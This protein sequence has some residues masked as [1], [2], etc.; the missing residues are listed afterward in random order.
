LF[1]LRILIEEEVV[2]I[3]EEFFMVGD[4]FIEVL[5]LVLLVFVDELFSSFRL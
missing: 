2:E 1:S 4:D 3:D 5:D